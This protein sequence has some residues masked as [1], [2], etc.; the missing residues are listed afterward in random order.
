MTKFVITGDWHLDAVTNGVDRYLSL[1]RSLGQLE[2]YIETSRLNHCLSQHLM[3]LGD[4]CDS[5]SDRAIRA[6]SRAL[7][8]YRISPSSFW[9]VGNHDVIERD[10]AGNTLSPLRAA[11]ARVLDQ[12]GF[13]MVDGVF[14]CWFPRTKRSEEYNP[15]EQA[16]RLARTWSIS[17]PDA[18]VL[19]LSHLECAALARGS[20]SSSMAR[21]RSIELPTKVF[22]RW[23]LPER[24][25]IVNGHY[26]NEQRCRVDGFDV[27]VPGTLQRL[28]FDEQSHNP[29][30]LTAKW[31][32]AGWKVTRFGFRDT[33]PM[34]TIGVAGA[35]RILP[36]SFVRIQPMVNDT[37][38]DVERAFAKAVER[39]AA[40]VRVLP[41]PKHA[42]VALDA[43]NATAKRDAVK[44]VHAAID[45]FDL[46][47]DVKREL[48]TIL[49]ECEI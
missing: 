12:P 15:E 9:L 2:L 27:H 8:T 10:G 3:F 29:G 39:G 34:V 11:G 41:I 31:R 47:P 26:H 18:P 1:D 38:A 45:L 48:E 32:D 17:F 14:V 24:T 35:S 44:S 6:I 28:R 36:G 5:T 13:L 23:F 37:V 4:L 30:W 43:I 21:G 20:E 33:D 7:V 16:R 25:L 46:D 19:V 40:N 42:P 49:A 22:A